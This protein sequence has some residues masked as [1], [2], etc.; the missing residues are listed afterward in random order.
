MTIIKHIIAITMFYFINL[1][2]GIVTTIA[3][4]LIYA[5]FEYQG[6]LDNRICDAIDEME[7]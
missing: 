4:G 5:R 2:S 7:K 6:S 3:I 1:E